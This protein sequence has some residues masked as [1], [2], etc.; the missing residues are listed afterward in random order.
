MNNLERIETSYVGHHVSSG[1]FVFYK[2]KVT[3]MIYTLLITNKKNELWIVKGHIENN[4]DHINTAFREFEEEVGMKR[5]ML[6]YI[7]FLVNIQYSFNEWGG[8][9]TKE[10]YMHIFESKEKYDLSG[11]TGIEDIVK[12]EWYKVDDALKR[13]SFNKT[14]LRNALEVFENHLAK[15]E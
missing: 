9:N 13:I 8:N 2:D 15:N 6:E 3:D 5:D 12:I 14:E 4:E 11:N 10:V 7:D 1:G